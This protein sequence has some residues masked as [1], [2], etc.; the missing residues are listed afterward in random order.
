VVGEVELARELS[1]GLHCL[2]AKDERDV[3]LL[4]GADDGG[5]DEVEVLFEAGTKD[6]EGVENADEG[7][8]SS[9]LVEVEAEVEGLEHER[10][11]VREVGLELGIKCERDGLDDVDDDDL[12]TGVG[13]RRPEVADGG[14]NRSEM[15]A[16][17]LLDHGDELSKVLKVVLL[18]SDGTAAHDVEEGWEDLREERDDLEA[19]RAEDVHDRIDDGSVVVAKGRVIEDDEE[20]GEGD[21]G[22]VLVVL[23]TDVGGMCR[24]GRVERLDV[25]VVRD[26]LD[27]LKT[28]RRVSCVLEKTKER[29]N[30]PN[31]GKGPMLPKFPS[32]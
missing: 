13:C 11:E 30:E 21:R 25:S 19:E 15:V 31:D 4:K 14:H 16:D 10:E 12:Q 27:D 32:P 3:G 26:A 5:D 28:M 20:G 1:D 8:L 24:V 22:V 29:G 23:R 17:V 7:A 18:Q 9:R 6:T 2:L